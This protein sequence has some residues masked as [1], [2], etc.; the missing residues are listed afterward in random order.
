MSSTVHI[1]T[2]M[3]LNPNPKFPST[4][5]SQLEQATAVAS[6][7]SNLVNLSLH[8][9]HIILR[10][11]SYSFH[12][13]GSIPKE[14]GTL[15]KLVNLGLSTNEF[16][17]KLPKTV[18]NLSQLEMLDFSCNSLRGTIFFSFGQLKNLIQFSLNSN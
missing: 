9:R 10:L 7:A 6:S 5:T 2:S 17:G 14:I 11:H 13:R 3:T 16:Q 1:S 12:P 18:S 4:T 8:L 15:T